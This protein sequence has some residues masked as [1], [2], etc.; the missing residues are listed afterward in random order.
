VGLTTLDCIYRVDHVP[1]ADEKVVAQDSLLVAGGPATNAAV[2]FRHLGHQAAVV[3]A[4]GQ[5]PITSLI[6]TDLAAQQVELSDLTPN[7]PNPP[8]LSTILVT[9]A[10]LAAHHCQYFG[11]RAGLSNF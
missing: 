4:L 2:M 3:S 1:T 8:P 7:S 11:T 10:E 6:R 9:A 5:H